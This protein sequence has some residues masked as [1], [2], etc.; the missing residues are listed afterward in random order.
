[1]LAA[2][3][4]DRRITLKAPVATQDAAGQSDLTW[5]DVATVWAQVL[6]LRGRELV[7]AQAD[8]PQA[9]LKIRIRWMAGV[10]EAMRVAYEGTDYGV[11]R[12]AEIGRRDGLELLV[13]RPG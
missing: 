13:R 5:T 4:L 9:D 12:V 6:P 7:T 2:G 11:F 3:K 1:M 8:V 10:T